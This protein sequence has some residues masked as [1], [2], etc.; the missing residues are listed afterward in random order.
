MSASAR[1]TN[2]AARASPYRRRRAR[3]LWSDG[4]CL[5]TL[6]ELAP[7]PPDEAPCCYCCCLFSAV[8]PLLFVIVP[9]VCAF[10]SLC[11]FVCVSSSSSSPADIPS[12]FL[13]VALSDVIVGAGS[14]VCVPLAYR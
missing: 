13:P 11:V 3:K 10:L 5:P 2:V 14:A 12:T 8:S 1:A 7:T 6:A 4:S 9:R